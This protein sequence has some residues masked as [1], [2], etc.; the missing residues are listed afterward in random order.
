[1]SLDTMSILGICPEETLADVCKDTRTRRLTVALLTLAI[2]SKQF[3]L[4]G[5]R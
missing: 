2:S 1:M 5:E 4:T 3:K